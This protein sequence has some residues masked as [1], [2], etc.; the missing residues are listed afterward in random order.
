MERNKV[1]SM[2]GL[3][4]KAGKTAGGEFAVETAITKRKA[5]LV[6]V[7]EEASDNTIKKFKSKCEFH[8]V[9]VVICFTKDELGRATGKDIRTSVVVTDDGFAGAIIKLFDKDHNL[10]EE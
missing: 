7:S 10:T 8:G 2:L 4:C 5:R 3:A 9:P 1:L 6:I